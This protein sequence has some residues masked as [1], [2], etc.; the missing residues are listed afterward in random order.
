[1]ETSISVYFI[2][3]TDLTNP[4]GLSQFWEYYIGTQ[5]PAVLSQIFSLRPML[6]DRDMKHEE[7]KLS[8]CWREG[9]GQAVGSEVCFQVSFDVYSFLLYLQHCTYKLPLFLFVKDTT[10][11]SPDEQHGVLK[12]LFLFCGLRISRSQGAHWPFSELP[13]WRFLCDQS[14]TLD[15]KG[16]AFFFSEGFI[17]PLLYFLLRYLC[18]P[19]R[20]RACLTYGPFQYR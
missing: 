16:L 9:R 19:L 12:C 15:P 17:L 18:H 3:L 11:H 8:V 1:M 20:L 2:P 14:Q 13:M 10:W 6:D 5:V 7:K 4:K